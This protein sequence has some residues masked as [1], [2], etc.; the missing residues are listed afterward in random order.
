MKVARFLLGSVL[1]LVSLLA[2]YQ[3]VLAQ[4]P[5]P[6]PTP[7]PTPKPDKIDLTT[8]YPTLEA[9]SGNSFEFEVKLLYSGTQKRNFTVKAAVPKDWI[10]YITPSYPKDKRI[11]EIAIDPIVGGTETIL[12]NTGPLYALQ[13]DPGSYPI[14]IEATS[15]DLKGSIQVKAV[16]TARYGLAMAPPQNTPYSTKVTAGKDNTYQVD[17]KN[18]GSA[19]VDDISFTSD[20]PEGW[21]VTF[22]PDK[23]S[24]LPSGNT[25]TVTVNIKP[26]AKAI[27]GD[28]VV[29]VRSNG[30]QANA[31]K[32]DI[33]VTVETPTIWGWTGIAIIV[34]VVAGLSFV[35]LRFS[36]R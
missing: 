26:G 22:S 1:I 17:L 25:Q 24:S 28:Y 6:T 15:G 11:Q 36:R 23:V 31:D 7:T 30:K 19:A 5:T 20:K 8:T 12:V 29:T 13:V 21:T 10:A 2:I 27:A 32:M 16:V 3:P 4:E 9:I 14:T 18:A 34:L 33:R 35:I